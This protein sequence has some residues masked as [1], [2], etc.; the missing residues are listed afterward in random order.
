MVRENVLWRDLLDTAYDGDLEPADYLTE[1]LI[2]LRH[3]RGGQPPVTD[4]QLRAAME[5]V[6]RQGGRCE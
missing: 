5:A 4:E 6:G 2:E 3:P 1:V